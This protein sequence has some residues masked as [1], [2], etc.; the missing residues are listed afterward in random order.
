M[1]EPNRKL[2]INIRSSGS[3]VP[4]S[5]LKA[6]FRRFY[7]SAK[8]WNLMKHKPLAPYQ[9]HQD[10]VQLG[11]SKGDSV[12]I[13]G[14]LSKVGH[15]EGGAN[16]L[17]KLILDIITTEGT[18]A[19]P[20]LSIEKSS[21]LDTV[22]DSGRV[23]DLRIIDTPYAISRAVMKMPNTYRSVHPTHSV[24][25]IGKNAERLVHGHENAKTNFG[26]GTP[27]YKL[28]D[29]GGKLLGVGIPFG[30]VTFVHV[31]E[32]VETN[33]PIQVY[34]PK[35]FNTSVIGTDGR[36]HAMMVKAHD[37]SKSK[38]RIDKPKSD[39]NRNLFLQVLKTHFGLKTG[40]I[41]RGQSWLVNLQ[42]VYKA[43]KWLLSKGITIY[44]TEEQFDKLGLPAI[45][46]WDPKEIL[47]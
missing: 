1:Q 24:C 25:A 29:L 14:S 13:H 27:W 33:F 11:I 19:V 2:L 17:V 41:G 18:L 4:N 46:N 40:T 38:S 16:T 47:V 32:D 31:I 26:R 30:S 35:S 36:M 3:M 7:R 21:M 42:N 20:A 34:Y 43:Q 22:K 5:S 15:V 44:T 12:I 6:L 37:P 39:W 10:L 23:L 28:M 8:K 45:E 9:L